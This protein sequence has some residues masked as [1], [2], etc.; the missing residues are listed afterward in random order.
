MTDRRRCPF[1][2]TV[3]GE[4]RGVF[5]RRWEECTG[6]VRFMMLRI[7][8]RPLVAPES[9]PQIMV[10]VQLLL[11]PERAGHQERPKPFWGDTE[12]GLKDALELEQ[13]LVVKN[14]V[15]EVLDRDL[16][17]LQAETNRVPGKRVVA[18]LACKTLL[19]R[20]CDDF[21]IAYQTR[22]TIV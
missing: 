4:N 16:R 17:L 7:Q 19:L 2:D 10:G 11:D 3:H 18:L 13:R 12:I 6:R 14:H 1:A 9:V 8:K 20:R 22:R 15:G 5:E 21:A